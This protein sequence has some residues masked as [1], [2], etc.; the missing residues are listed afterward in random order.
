MA[1]A[2]TFNN[3]IF[4]VSLILTNLSG[5][6][7]RDGFTYNTS[8]SAWLSVRNQDTIFLFLINP[9][10]LAHM[11][12]T[13]AFLRVRNHDS[14]F[15]HLIDPFRLAHMA[16]TIALFVMWNHNGVVFN[17]I[18]PLG[19]T[20]VANAR[21]LFLNGNID[22]HRSFFGY[23]LR[24]HDCSR[25]SFPCSTGFCVASAGTASTA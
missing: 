8:A 2:P 13:G 23:H 15:L 20:N 25:N 21:P 7:Y 12:D 24:N 17:L 11:A 1:A 6:F 18:R 9:L 3:S 22:S 16:D 4:P 19:L 14:V 10:S 5:L